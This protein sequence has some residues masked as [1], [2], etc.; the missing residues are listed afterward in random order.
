VHFSEQVEAVERWLDSFLKSTAKLTHEVAS[1]ENLINGFLLSTAPPVQLSEAIID[2]D[3][4]LLAIRRYGEGAKD[5]WNSTI[6]GLK[7]MEITM[8][9]PVKIFL[10]TDLRVF[11]VLSKPVSLLSFLTDP[12]GRMFGANLSNRK[13]S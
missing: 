2:H 9:E 12:S 1:L 11:K 5:F 13:G 7:K 10:Q 8:V 4:T 6:G 3:Y